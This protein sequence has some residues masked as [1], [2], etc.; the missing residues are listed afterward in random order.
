MTP[1]TEAILEA[2]NGPQVAHHIALNPDLAMELNRSTP[3][4]AGMIIARLSDKLSASPAQISK[5]P[6]PI[7][8][9]DAGAGSAAVSDGLKNIG[10]AKFE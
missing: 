9:E 4:K 3:I 6:A 5:A 8:S 2:D 10:K 1:A 7:E